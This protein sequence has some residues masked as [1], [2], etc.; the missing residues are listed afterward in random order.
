[1]P[2]NYPQLIVFREK[3]GDSYYLVESKEAEYKM[4]LEVLT[5]RNQYGWYSWMKDNKP[6]FTGT[7]P[8]YTK[9]DLDK[10]PESLD[11][12]RKKLL[13]ELIRWEKAEK[14]SEKLKND[15]RLIQEAIKNSDGKLAYK[16]LDQYSEDEYSGWSRE[17]YTHIK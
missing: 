12:E 9:E 8:T 16:L 5:E 2:V 6:Y 15:Y 11:S 3:H 14:E 17:S 7:K 4:F 13:S 1:M 10:M